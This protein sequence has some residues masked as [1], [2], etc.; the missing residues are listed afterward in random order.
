[1][2]YMRHHAIVVTSWDRERLDEAHAEASRIFADVTSI[3]TGTAE[4]YQS[5]LI[6][7]DGSK[8]GWRESDEG[9]DRRHEFL[10]WLE[11]RRYDG[12]A[13]LQWVEVQFGDDNG[14]D[15]IVQSSADVPEGT[16]D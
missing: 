3:A 10:A 7:P 14:D 12:D 16:P 2:G 15:R 8:E 13:R 1:M 5:F 9:D 4:G 11:I 6:P